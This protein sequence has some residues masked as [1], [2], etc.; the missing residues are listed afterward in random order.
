MKHPLTKDSS[1]KKMIKK[2]VTC[3]QF[4][5]IEIDT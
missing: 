3:D 1:P 5:K 2:D 4:N